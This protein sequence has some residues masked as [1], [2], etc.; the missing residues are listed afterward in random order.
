[1]IEINPS[2]RNFTWGNNQRNLILAKLDRIF[3]SAEWEAAF[4]LVKVLGLAKSLSDHVPLLVDSGENM[5][6]AKKKFRF[7]KW[8]PEREDFKVVRKAWSSKCPIV[9][10]METWQFRVRT[11]RR[12]VRSWASNVVAELNR[13]KQ[14]VSVEFN[15]LDTESENRIMDDHE[16]ENESVSQEAR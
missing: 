4:P 7:E 1:L 9:G 2:N 3:I 11:F 15:W 14:A 12:M 8:W 10:G 16:K 13:E 5:V 6:W